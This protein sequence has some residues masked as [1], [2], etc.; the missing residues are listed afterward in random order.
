MLLDQFH[1]RCLAVNRGCSALALQQMFMEMN[2]VILD[3]KYWGSI[4]HRN[5]NIQL[6]Y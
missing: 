3:P 6:Q 1:R 5:I 4:C 2:I